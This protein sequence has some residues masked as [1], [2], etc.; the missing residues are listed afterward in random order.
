MRNT[1]DRL[2][3]KVA[4]KLIKRYGDAALEHAIKEN[5]A[6]NERGDKIATITWAKIINA[7]EQTQAAAATTH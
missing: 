4:V 2:I 6:A 7:I 3:W 1:N 5:N